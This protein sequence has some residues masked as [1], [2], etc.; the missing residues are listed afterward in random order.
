MNMPEV[1]IEAAGDGYKLVGFEELDRWAKMN[2]PEWAI[3]SRQ[4]QEF[5][6]DDTARL[7]LLAAALL[8]RM[9]SSDEE[10]I[11]LLREGRIVPVRAALA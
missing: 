11:A 1:K 7:K 5:G 4:C 2:V 3:V 6:L 9:V 10:M 8:K